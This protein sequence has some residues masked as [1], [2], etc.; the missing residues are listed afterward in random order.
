MFE[1]HKLLEGG[2]EVGKN[3]DYETLF[4]Y[5]KG[6]QEERR[7]TP[8]DASNDDLIH[9]MISNIEINEDPKPEGWKKIHEK[10]N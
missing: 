7:M 4:H 5:L 9:E 10:K 2:V 6:R 3:I 8:A 1:E